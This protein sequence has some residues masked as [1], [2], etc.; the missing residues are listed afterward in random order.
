MTEPGTTLDPS[1]PART[2]GPAAAV[3]TGTSRPTVPTSPAIVLHN[4]EFTRYG[5]TPSA[6]RAL[7]D[8]G[9]AMAWTALSL[10]QSTHRTR[11]LAHLAA[12]HTN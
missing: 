9:L 8:G 2:P 11:L 12:R 1:P 4:P 7:L 3:A 5:T 10:A 6:D